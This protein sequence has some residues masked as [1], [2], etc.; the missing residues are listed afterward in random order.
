MT[1]TVEHNTAYRGNSSRQ[2]NTDDDVW[3]HYGNIMITN[4]N[5]GFMPK[6]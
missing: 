5:T 4:D 2:M 6:N 3:K 1:P